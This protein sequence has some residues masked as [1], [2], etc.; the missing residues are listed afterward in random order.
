[1][2]VIILTSNSEKHGVFWQSKLAAIYPASL[3]INVFEDWPQGA[4]NWLGTLNAWKQA[5]IIAWEKYGRKLEQEMEEGASV[6]LYH[7]AGKGQRMYPLTAVEKF[8]KSAIKLPCGVTEPQTLLESVIK[9]TS[10]LSEYRKGR[11]SVFWTDQLFLTDNKPDISKASVRVMCQKRPFPSI[12]QWESG[13]WSQY[14]VIGIGEDGCLRHLEKVDYQTAKHYSLS[15]IALSLGD[16]SI[17][18]TFLKQLMAEF[19]AEL[20]SKQTQMDVESFLLMPATLSIEDYRSL[21]AQK[22][23]SPQESDAHFGRIQ[24]LL[25]KYGNFSYALED[26][27]SKGKWWDFG[28][29][30]NYYHSLMSMCN[31][32]ELREFLYPKMPKQPT[33]LDLD[34]A[35]ILVNCSIHSGKVR[36]SILYNVQ[37]NRVDCNEVLAI[38]V[39]AP[40]L[41]GDHA[42]VYE[43]QSG[44]PLILEKDGLRADLTVDDRKIVMYTHIDKDPRADWNRKI[45]GNPYCYRELAEQE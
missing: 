6:A 42:L 34:E 7:T 14:G 28:S 1:M 29:V 20:E 4:G 24:R 9:Q 25:Q 41:Y 19:A 10:L 30:E 43:V 5:Q 3:V 23:V 12:E 38:D 11:L 13:L 36:N 44:D 26:I 17:S 16:F 31:Q 39:E 33:H 21:R 45:E 8:N 22:G 2:N 27:G 32:K 18:S 40:T 35:S 37:A 15:G